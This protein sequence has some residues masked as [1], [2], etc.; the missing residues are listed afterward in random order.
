MLQQP[1]ILFAAEKSWATKFGAL[2]WSW[3]PLATPILNHTKPR[4]LGGFDT[5]CTTI[6]ATWYHL[7]S[8]WT[9]VTLLLTTGKLSGPFRTIQV[10]HGIHFSGTWVRNLNILKSQNTSP[11][12]KTH[13]SQW[14]YPLVICY[15]AI[16]L[17]KM[18]IEIVDLPIENGDVP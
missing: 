6:C 5:I 17:L 10:V 11:N 18:A 12:A 9:T 7:C 13:N 1:E 2:K 3:K 14:M 4:L 8:W 16:M 15:I